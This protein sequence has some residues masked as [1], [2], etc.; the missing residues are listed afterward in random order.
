MA[1]PECV[2][3]VTLR[4][5][6]HSLAT[7]IALEPVQLTNKLFQ[8]GLVPE[9]LVK[10]ML[11]GQGLDYDKATKLV[12]AVRKI[13][14]NSSQPTE[15][16]EEFMNVLNESTGLESFVELVRKQYEDNKQAQAL[17]KVKGHT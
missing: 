5:C 14:G 2:E 3:V 6:T 7:G 10:M 4:Q 1:T 13:V 11:S 15:K 16:F 12:M 8:K 9:R 17:A